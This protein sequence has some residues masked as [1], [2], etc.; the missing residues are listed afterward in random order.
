[1]FLKLCIMAKK[2]EKA[3]VVELAQETIDIKM[4]ESENFEDS[5]DILIV[6][7]ML[8]FAGDPTSVDQESLIK[9]GTFY[10][11]RFE[12]ESDAGKRRLRYTTL[13]MVSNLY[14]ILKIMR[15][16]CEEALLNRG[17]DEMRK[18]D[19]LSFVLLTSK[20]L[21]PESPSAKAQVKESIEWAEKEY[22]S[23]KQC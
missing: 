3:K 19:M 9:I 23:D 7:N 13:T 16:P 6:L 15:V 12:V 20:L 22:K 1:M 8:M 21:N 17:M 5:I 2:G 4:G 14:E 11:T 18:K 10:Q